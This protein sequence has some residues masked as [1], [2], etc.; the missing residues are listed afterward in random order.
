MGRILFLS[1][2]TLF[3]V[4]LAASLLGTTAQAQTYGGCRERIRRAEIRL[5]QAI[6]RHGPNSHQARTRQRELQRERASC[7]MDRYGYWR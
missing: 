6:N 5:Q 2:G 4:L 3:A 7:R 1:R